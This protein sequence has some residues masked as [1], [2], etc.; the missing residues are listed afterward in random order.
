M[1]DLFVVELAGVHEGVGQSGLGGFG[2]DGIAVRVVGITVYDGSG[3]IDDQPCAAQAV[4]E[5]EVDGRLIDRIDRVDHAAVMLS[6]RLGI[7]VDIWL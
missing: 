1:S 6:E 7:G 5:M 2:G 4:V 3:G